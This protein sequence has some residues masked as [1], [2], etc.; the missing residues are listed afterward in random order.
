MPAGSVSGIVRNRTFHRELFF[1]SCLLFN[2]C[3]K[4]ITD[5]EGILIRHLK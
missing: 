1:I 5:L 2:P 3:D 4:Y